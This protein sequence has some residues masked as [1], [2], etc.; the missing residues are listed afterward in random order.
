[1]NCLFYIFL[2]LLVT[3]DDTHFGWLICEKNFTK[4]YF[5]QIIALIQSE[6]LQ[7]CHFHVLILVA[8]ANEHLRLPSGIYLKG[9]YLQI[10]LIESDY[11]LFNI[12]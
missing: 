7:N 5:R 1:M 9:F 2:L 12:S 10:I 8:A 4:Y 11:N 6:V 3:A